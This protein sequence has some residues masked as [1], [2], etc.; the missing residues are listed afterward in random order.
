M[1]DALQVACK[2]MAK[3]IEGLELEVDQRGLRG[4]EEKIE[5]LEGMLRESRG[6]GAV[7]QAGF[8]QSS[9]RF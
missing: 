1:K 5:D 8:G 3:R 6:E 2:Y 9:V 4:S 7:G